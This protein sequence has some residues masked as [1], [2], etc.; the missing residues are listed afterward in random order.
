MIEILAL[1]VKLAGVVFLILASIGLIRFDDPFQRMHAATKA[2]TLGAGMVLIGTM[3][4]KGNMD[5]TLTGSLTLVFLLLTVPVASH[6]L[7]RAAYMS[8]AELAGIDNADA[9]RGKIGRLETPLEEAIEKHN[10]EAAP[11]AGAPAMVPAS[12]AAQGLV[13]PAPMDTIPVSGHVP[14]PER[15]RF[16]AIGDAAPTLARRAA[17]FAARTALPLTAVVAVDTAY[18]DATENSTETLRQVCR[19]ILSMKKAMPKL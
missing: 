2:G 19:L 7:A 4:S 10:F 13:R 15:V 11:I 8:G 14:P 1:L 17:G 6:L 5:A 12:A 3:L 9:L 16:A 18:A